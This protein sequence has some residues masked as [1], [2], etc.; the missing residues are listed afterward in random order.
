M[1]RWAK[2]VDPLFAVSDE[3]TGIFTEQDGVNHGKDQP[4]VR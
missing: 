1:I 2:S 3:E 4:C